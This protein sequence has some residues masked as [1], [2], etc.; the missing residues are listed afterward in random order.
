MLPAA[1]RLRSAA[2]FRTT[3]RQGRRSA[4]GPVV[5][6]LLTGQPG[7][8]RAGVVVPRSVGGSVERHRVARRIRGGLAP[9]MPG[10]A[11]GTLVVVRALPG[12]SADRRLGERVRAAVEQVSATG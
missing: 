4:S 11:P 8:A 6:H 2:E 5:V 1:H 7:P 12:A 10:L 9:L 3:S